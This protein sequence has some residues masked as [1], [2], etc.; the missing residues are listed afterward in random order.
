MHNILFLRVFRAETNRNY[1]NNHFF[2]QCQIFAGSVSQC[3][4]F[5]LPC[6][7]YCKLLSLLS[8]SRSPSW[9]LRQKPVAP[10]PKPSLLPARR[11]T[12]PLCGGSTSPA[13]GSAPHKHPPPPG[14]GQ[15]R[16]LR[17]NYP[18]HT[19]A[20]RRLADLLLNHLSVKNVLL[21][22]SEEG[23]LCRLHD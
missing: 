13:P 17:G 3:E 12:S 7:P 8:G 2:S 23:H 20:A 21:V 4:D 14:V 18:N 5:L 10:R 11:A 15:P 19:T 1:Y 6:S 22:I 16:T 9:R